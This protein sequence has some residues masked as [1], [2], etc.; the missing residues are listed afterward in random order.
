MQHHPLRVEST[1]LRDERAQGAGWKV[2]VEQRADHPERPPLEEEGVVLPQPLQQGL[3]EPLPAADHV[4]V[5]LEG[6]L[7]ADEVLGLVPVQRHASGWQED[8]LPVLR[9]V[10]G[11]RDEHVHAAHQV[12]EPARRLPC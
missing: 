5:R 8:A 6:I 4:G 11:I 2:G 7:V 3:E 9:E 1:H 10:H 12:H